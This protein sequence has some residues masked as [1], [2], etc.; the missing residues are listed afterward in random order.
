M[1]NNNN[2]SSI[3]SSNM[4]IEWKV[5]HSIAIIDVKCEGT[6]CVKIP[7]RNGGWHV[8]KDFTCKEKGNILDR[9]NTR[10]EIR[11]WVN[12]Q[13]RIYKC[14]I[15]QWRYIKEVD[16]IEMKIEAFERRRDYPIEI[17]FTAS[18][19]SY[20][21][22]MPNVWVSEV[23]EYYPRLSKVPFRIM[24]PKLR[25]LEENEWMDC[26]ITNKRRDYTGMSFY[27]G[28]YNIL[29]VSNLNCSKSTSVAHLFG[30]GGQ[31]ELDNNNNNNSL[32]IRPQA[33][34]LEE[35]LEVGTG[36]T[37]I[38]YI[39]DIVSRHMYKVDRPYKHQEGALKG[40]FTY[41]SEGESEKKDSKPEAF[42]KAKRYLI[43]P[44]GY[45]TWEKMNPAT[46]ATA[47]KRSKKERV[48]Q[49]A[50]VS[51]CITK[52]IDPVILNTRFEQHA[53]PDYELLLKQM[54]D[55]CGANEFEDVQVLNA[56]RE[57]LLALKRLQMEQNNNNS[58]EEM[59]ESSQ[60]VIEDD[61][62]EEADTT[63]DDEF[64]MEDV[65]H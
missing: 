43:N 60:A 57:R 26:I 19:I 16:Q 9:M 31:K 48:D 29:T 2:S 25:K 18:H 33:N 10:D 28:N 58:I 11:R 64:A 5:G 32:R 59:K 14:S 45:L 20:H 3:D 56:E 62:D 35:G 30:E 39:S 61:D 46:A 49:F 1:S 65:V 24:A 21:D 44:I 34:G 15:N 8:H 63:E 54:G 52:D 13:N 6:V 36:S 38:R 12:E 27:D 55:C 53:D 23:N 22:I 40:E 17:K 50:T 41:H 4:N 42:D 37:G 7:M 51:T 47:A